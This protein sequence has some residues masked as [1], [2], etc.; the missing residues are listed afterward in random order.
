[1]AFGPTRVAHIRTGTNE[2]TVYIGR[3]RAGQP[4]GFGNPFALGPDGGRTTVITKYETWLRT[5]ESFGNRDA[6]PARRQWILDNLHILRGKTLL[7]FCS[8]QPCHGDVLVTLIEETWP[9][10]PDDAA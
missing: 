2:N 1:M 10:S 8:P 6:T 5:G 7:C 9:L 4:W 3:P